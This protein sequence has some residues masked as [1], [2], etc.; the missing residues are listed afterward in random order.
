MDKEKAIQDFS[1]GD[2]RTYS[3]EEQIH[4]IKKIPDVKLLESKD[5]KLT[6]TGLTSYLRTVKEILDG[7]DEENI[8][9]IPKEILNEFTG[10]FSGLFN[11]LLRI[12]QTTLNVN[13]TP[14][15]QMQNIVNDF[16]AH[17]NSGRKILIDAIP[18]IKAYAPQNIDTDSKK[19]ADKKIEALLQELEKHKKNAEIRA[20]QVEKSAK[21]I[22]QLESNLSDADKKL[23]DLLSR[24]DIR[25]K[26]FEFSDEALNN[27]RRANYWL[28]CG[29]VPLS[30]ILLGIIGHIFYCFKG[31]FIDVTYN[32]FADKKLIVTDSFSHTVL[33][34]EFIKSISIR[35]L[36]ISLLIYFLVLA[37]K[38][39]NAQM[40][41][42]I[43]NTHKTNS[44]SS[45]VGLI[46]K[47]TS[48]ANQEKF[49]VQASQIIYSHQKSGYSG[50]EVGPGIFNKIVEKVSN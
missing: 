43:V 6:F 48:P 46:G 22:E 2:A 8:K 19:E 9:N 18:L 26:Q 24:T 13:E 29:I 44:L 42:Y 25:Q 37:V 21:S 32:A 34:F 41:N 47:I 49:I 38:N 35:V 1:Q 28:Y 36:F 5:Q 17:I 20:A 39:Y 15:R 23:K 50:K 12:K 16:A 11:L 7:I 4:I 14:Q 33:L 10:I 31:E 40:H 3:L 45:I 30:I 27:K